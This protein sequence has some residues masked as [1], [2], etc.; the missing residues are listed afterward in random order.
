MMAH[1]F[2]QIKATKSGF[3][4]KKSMAHLRMC[5]YLASCQVVMKY[6]FQLQSQ[7]SGCISLSGNLHLSFGFLTSPLSAVRRKC[8]VSTLL[9]EESGNPAKEKKMK[10]VF[11]SVIG[12][13]NIII[14]DSVITHSSQAESLPV[15]WIWLDSTDGSGVLIT[16]KGDK[17][18]HYVIIPGIGDIR[19]RF[20]GDD[21]WRLYKGAIEDF[22]K[23]V[24]E[25]VI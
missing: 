21:S 25:S 8:K 23:Y 16:P 6:C 24:E 10:N 19:F 22:K 15:G 1:L 13:N 20:H 5:L 11:R 14:T 17:C 12:N 18:I 7:E 4:Y 9:A 2:K 3:F